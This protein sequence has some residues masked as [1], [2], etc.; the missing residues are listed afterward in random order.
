MA[1]ISLEQQCRIENGVLVCQII[2]RNGFL[3]PWLVKNA[4][5]LGFY[6]ENNQGENFTHTCHSQDE[7]KAKWVYMSRYTDHNFTWVEPVY[8]SVRCP[9][10]RSRTI[11]L[12]EVLTG[13]A[14]YQVE[15]GVIIGMGEMQY[16][17][18]QKVFGECL[19]CQH[20]WTVRNASMIDHCYVNSEDQLR[21]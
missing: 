12:H 17:D 15:D 5:K 21:S 11:E 7:H 6:D 4:K 1:K 19:K 9:K 10:C 18:P 16:S 13:E 8:V 14:I 2:I 3:S 20:C